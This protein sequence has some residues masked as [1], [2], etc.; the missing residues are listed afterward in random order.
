[1]GENRMAIV[2]ELTEVIEVLP[3][4]RAVAMEQMRSI[5]MNFDPGARV[6]LAPRISADMLAPFHDRDAQ[7]EFARRTLGNCQP[8]KPRSDDNEIGGGKDIDIERIANLWPASI[9][10]AYASTICCE[11]N[12]SPICAL[13]RPFVSSIAPGTLAISLLSNRNML[14]NHF[15]FDVGRD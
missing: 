6:H 5:A 2:V 1:M 3:D 11:N 15:R 7:P 9:V 14:S 4:L 12:N 8:E 13:D 10:S